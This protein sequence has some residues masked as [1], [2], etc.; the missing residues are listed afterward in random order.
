MDEQYLYYR[1]KFNDWDYSEDYGADNDDAQFADIS[2]FD[3]SETASLWLLDGSPY[4]V[5]DNISMQPEKRKNGSQDLELDLST[6]DNLESELSAPPI[7]EP[8]ETKSGRMKCSRR[9]GRAQTPRTLYPGKITYGSAHISRKLLD[10]PGQPSLNPARPDS[11]SI[12]A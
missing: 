3:D 8:S 7:E 12:L 10:N 5:R 9:S 4:S 6:F 11:P 2:D 1:A